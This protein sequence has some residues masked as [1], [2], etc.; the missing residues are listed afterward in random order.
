MKSH[1]SKVY[2]KRALGKVNWVLVYKVDKPIIDTSKKVWANDREEL[3]VS[4]R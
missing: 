2:G 4:Y 1:S 3:A